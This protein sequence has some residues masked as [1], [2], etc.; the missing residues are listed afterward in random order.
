MR[1]HATWLLETIYKPA[2]RLKGT[3]QGVEEVRRWHTR[4]IF[5]PWG[6]G[7]RGGGGSWLC[8]EAFP[9]P[10]PSQE[11]IPFRSLKLLGDVRMSLFCHCQKH[12]RRPS[13]CRREERECYRFLKLLETCPF[14]TSLLEAPRRSSSSR[15]GER[16]L[17]VHQTSGNMSLFRHHCWKHLEDHLLAEG[18]R[19][20]YMS[21]KLLETCPFW[22]ALLE[23]AR[24]LSSSRRG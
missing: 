22:T 14:W 12:L 19:E 16:I 21:L 17:H 4:A 9:V 10:K 7:G 2:L 6:G 18:G 24:R 15:K 8:M 1:S 3:W 5:R 13:S 23:A 20:S 11:N